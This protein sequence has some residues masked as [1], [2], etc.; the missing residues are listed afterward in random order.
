MDINTYLTPPPPTDGQSAWTWDSWWQGQ[1]LGRPCPKTFRW[2]GQR[3][4]I[5]LWWSELVK[6]KYSRM[7]NLIS[8]S[9]APTSWGRGT[10]S[11]YSWPDPGRLR[12]AN[13][14][15][16]SLALVHLVWGDRGLV[17]VGGGG[18]QADLTIVSIIP[19]RVGV[20]SDLKETYV[21]DIIIVMGKRRNF[22]G[23]SNH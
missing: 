19:L 9:T 8:R 14:T 20:C 7:N 11:R 3:C 18:L 5:V 2:D 12:D 16:Q 23:P 1:L 13:G 17:I 10:R 15:F 6:T 21:Y 22:Q 4:G